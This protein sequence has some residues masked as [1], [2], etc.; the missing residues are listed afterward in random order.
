MFYL[1]KN[2]ILHKKKQETKHPQKTVELK[3]KQAKDKEC[4]IPQGEKCKTK[5]KFH[6]NII[7]YILS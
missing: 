6:K 3:S 4:S 5:Q 2:K 7:E 1:P